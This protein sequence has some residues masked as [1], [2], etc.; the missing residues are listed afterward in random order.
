[1]I[2]ILT[3]SP[4]LVGCCGS[5]RWVRVFVCSW[6][7][8][9]VILCLE[10]VF[11]PLKLYRACSPTWCLSVTVQVWRN[12]KVC[13][14]LFVSLCW[15]VCVMEGGRERERERVLLVPCSAGWGT[16]FLFRNSGTPNENDNFEVLSTWMRSN[17]PL[18]TPVSILH[19]A[20]GL[21]PHRE[22]EPPD[23]SKIKASFRELYWGSPG[24]LSLSF[25]AL[26][27][28][29]G[30]ADTEDMHQWGFRLSSKCTAWRRSH[31]FLQFY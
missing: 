15:Y 25:T 27:P 14:F 5:F 23:S 2:I 19:P 26:N 28:L 29:R 11:V 24:H 31:Y 3:R 13:V 9:Q 20:A 12:N 7:N 10:P 8:I 17:T 16:A 30:W 1:M 22:S 18:V 21:E 4:C 6:L